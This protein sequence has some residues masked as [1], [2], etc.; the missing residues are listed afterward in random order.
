[1][2]IES[3]E[4]EGEIRYVKRWFDSKRNKLPGVKRGQKC[5]SYVKANT[6]QKSKIH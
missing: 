6:N 4:L 3:I 2:N 5:L 1:L